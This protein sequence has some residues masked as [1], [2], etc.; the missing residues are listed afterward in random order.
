M[1]C[2]RYPFKCAC[3]NPTSFNYDCKYNYL[4][5]LEVNKNIN[6]ILFRIVYVLLTFSE[7]YFIFGALLQSVCLVQ[8]NCLSVREPARRI[9]QRTY[10]LCMCIILH[11]QLVFMWCTAVKVV[12]FC[13]FSSLSFC[14]CFFS[15]LALV[16]TIEVF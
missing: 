1:H 2:I 6:K 14:L 7:W 16:L 15:F 10:F 13:C 3:I 4:D 9:A 5:M 12:A 11:I 8:P